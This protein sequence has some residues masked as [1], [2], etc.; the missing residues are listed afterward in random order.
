ML[1]WLVL[2]MAGLAL[3]VLLAP[4]VTLLGTVFVLVPLAHLAPRPPM[5]A[6]TSFDCPFS[7]RHVNV[8]F[9]T[10]PTASEPVDVLACSMFTNGVACERKCRALM[11]TG[12]TPSPVVP[13]YALLAD[14]VAFRG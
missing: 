14:G 4:V 2:V 6:R 8:E 3:A 5:V 1:E 11:Q 9:L 12:W 10:S 13:R 7:R